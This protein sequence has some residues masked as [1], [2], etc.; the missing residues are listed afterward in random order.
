MSIKAAFV[1]ERA[2]TAQQAE[3]GHGLRSGKPPT[4][5]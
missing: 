4:R 2:A 5:A 3:G 1:L